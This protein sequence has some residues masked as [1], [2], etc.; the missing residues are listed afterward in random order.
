MGLDFGVGA[1]DPTPAA[2]P[3]SAALPSAPGADSE[4]EKLK[5]M[6]KTSAQ[7]A[8]T[9]A[10]ADPFAAQPPAPGFQTGMMGGVSQGMYNNMAAQNPAA[11]MQPNPAMGGMQ[12]NQPGMFNTGYGA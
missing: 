10:Q 2:Q 9:P 5:E 11:M 7:P 8:A 4:F 6:Y 1:S 3:G 12:M